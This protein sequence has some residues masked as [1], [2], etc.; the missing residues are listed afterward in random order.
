[1][2]YRGGFSSMKTQGKQMESRRK[3]EQGHIETTSFN[4][5]INYYNLYIHDDI[6]LIHNKCIKIVELGPHP[7]S[8]I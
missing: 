7:F 2:I 4:C 1:M 5:L 6:I 3:I 8:K